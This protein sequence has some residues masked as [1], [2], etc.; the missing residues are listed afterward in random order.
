MKLPYYC[1]SVSMLPYMHF[2]ATTLIAASHSV[3]KQVLSRHTG[4]QNQGK[5]Q[6]LFCTLHMEVFDAL[7][8]SNSLYGVHASLQPSKFSKTQLLVLVSM[9]YMYCMCKYA[10]GPR[11]AR[12]EAFSGRLCFLHPPV[13]HSFQLC[14]YPIGGNAL[15]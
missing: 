4:M 12:L 14:L 11:Q 13:M 3:H 8:C 9:M 2:Q 5:H 7:S 1:T 15:L 6:Y 10:I